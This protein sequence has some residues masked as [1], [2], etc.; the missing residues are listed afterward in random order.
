M[1]VTKTTTGKLKVKSA[2]GAVGQPAAKSVRVQGAGGAY[3][4][5]MQWGN[6]PNMPRTAKPN[7][8]ASGKLRVK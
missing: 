2:K 8:K 4:A 5:F 3:S 7:K 1:K 6:S